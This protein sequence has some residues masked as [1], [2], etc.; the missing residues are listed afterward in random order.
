ME[1]HVDLPPG[2]ASDRSTGKHMT[3]KTWRILIVLVCALAGAIMCAF[4]PHVVMARR[5]D[6]QAEPRT[7]YHSVF[8]GRVNTLSEPADPIEGM[9]LLAELG[10]AAFPALGALAVL[11]DRNDHPPRK[12]TQEGNPPGASAS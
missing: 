1:N 3:M 4:P 6:G 11:R 7:E 2:Q 12:P 5:Y 9:R 10:I 8:T